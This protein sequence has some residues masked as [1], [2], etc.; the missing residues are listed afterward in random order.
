MD[1]G[2]P[3]Y[4]KQGVWEHFIINDLTNCQN[5]QNNLITDFVCRGGWIAHSGTGAYP[6]QNGTGLI[7]NNVF[8]RGVVADHPIDPVDPPIFN[9]V[10]AGGMGVSHNWSAEI[11][12]DEVTFLRVGNCLDGQANTDMVSDGG[13]GQNPLRGLRQGPLWNIHHSTFEDWGDENYDG[14]VYHMRQ[15]GWHDGLDTVVSITT[16]AQTIVE[17]TGH[18]YPDIANAGVFQYPEIYFRNVVGPAAQLNLQNFMVEVIDANTFYL[19]DLVGAHIDSS[20]WP[21]FVSGQCARGCS[22]GLK[23]S[24]NTFIKAGIDADSIIFK[25]ANGNRSLNDLQGIVPG[26]EQNLPGMAD[27]LYEAGSVINP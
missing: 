26:W 13:E 4:T 6:R 14:R 25:Y 20:G 5:A 16:G 23:T 18:G 21:A 24:N 2:E 19:R 15:T 7:S 10:A 12:M 1:R 3:D 22:G 8:R 17:V 9:G 11:E 27:A